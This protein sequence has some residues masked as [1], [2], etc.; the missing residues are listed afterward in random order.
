MALFIEVDV[1]PEAARDSALAGRLAEVCPVNIFAR[2]P[3]GQVAIVEENVDECTLCEL[4]LKAAPPGCVEVR[5][6]YDGG[7]LLA[8]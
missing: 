3:Q 7:K 4:C 5:K 1:K 2:G 6:L 8:S